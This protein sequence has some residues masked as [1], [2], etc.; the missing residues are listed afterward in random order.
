MQNKDYYKYGSSNPALYSIQDY[1][2]IISKI[3]S[4][5]KI[6]NLLSVVTPALAMTGLANNNNNNL[7]RPVLIFGEEAADMERLNSWDGYN[8]DGHSPLRIMLDKKT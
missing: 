2:N 3:K 1:D 5:K 6:S 4:N 7:S 8:L